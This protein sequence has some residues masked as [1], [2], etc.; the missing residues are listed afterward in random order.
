MN[1][2]WLNQSLLLITKIENAQFVSKE[3][4]N[5]KSEIENSLKNFEDLIQGKKLRL[6]TE[7][8]GAVAV[9]MDRALAEI[10][11]SNLIA[12]AIKYR[13]IA[14]NNNQIKCVKFAVETIYCV[15]YYFEIILLEIYFYETVFN[16]QLTIRS[17]ILCFTGHCECPGSCHRTG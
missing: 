13:F 15:F 10:L 2:I 12:N 16:F 9:E 4:I 3:Q 11:F 7:L 17:I 1:R 5:L 14:Y 8:D 6:K